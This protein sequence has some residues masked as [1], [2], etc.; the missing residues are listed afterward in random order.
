MLSA[1]RAE[2]QVR[3]MGRLRLAFNT[4]EK[5]ERVINSAKKEHKLSWMED[6]GRYYPYKSTYLVF[7]APIPK[8]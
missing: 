4:K 2:R 6:V 8:G 1:R 5:A 7:Y 3:D